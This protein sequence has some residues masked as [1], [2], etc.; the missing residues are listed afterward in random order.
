M[1][2][3]RWAWLLAAESQSL[4]LGGLL[5]Q[6][7][8]DHPSTLPFVQPMY[9]HHCLRRTPPSQKEL[10]DV[11]QAILNSDLFNKQ[12]CTLDGL[13]KALEDTQVDVLDAFSNLPV[14]FLIMSRPLLLPKNSCLQRP[15]DRGEAS[16]HNLLEKEDSKEKV[17]KAVVEKSSGM[18]LL[19]SLQL[20]LTILSIGPE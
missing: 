5:R 12:Y 9:D 13:D 7:V 16:L 3:Q 15:T 8:E 10:I 11:L 18:F 4:H 20:D 14:N 17:L 1:E 19:A 2:E 6:V